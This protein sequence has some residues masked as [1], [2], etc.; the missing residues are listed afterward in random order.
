MSLDSETMN[1]LRRA[2]GQHM[3]NHGRIELG[4]AATLVGISTLT[5][6]HLRLADM[7]DSA[8]GFCSLVF[9]CGPELS[10]AE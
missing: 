10:G 6:V 1:R 9:T 5:L 7:R 3:I 2:L 8:A 4:S